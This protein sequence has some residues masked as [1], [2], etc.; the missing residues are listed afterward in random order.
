MKTEE[1]V[2][3]DFEY[4]EKKFGL[5]EVWLTLYMGSFMILMVY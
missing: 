3:E 4:S 5:Y 1:Q 2:E